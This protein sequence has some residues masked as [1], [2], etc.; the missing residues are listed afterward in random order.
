MP[1]VFEVLKRDHEEVESLLAALEAGPSATESAEEWRGR[2]REVATRL[3]MTESQH[4]VLEEE[5]FWPALREAAPDGL[6]LAD[7]A[8]RQE[9]KTKELLADLEKASEAQ[10]DRIVERFAID[11]RAHIA[12][13]EARAWPALR[14][15]IT[16]TRAAELGERIVEGKKRAPTR[17]HLTASANPVALKTAGA[18]MALT[19]R[20][21]DVVTGRGRD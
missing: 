3:V 13:E 14:R 16:D 20:V 5:H 15:A 19:D 18:A 4:E 17:P 6:D 21:R 8:I 2:R 10:F 11:G 7:H 1:D 12:F 9:T